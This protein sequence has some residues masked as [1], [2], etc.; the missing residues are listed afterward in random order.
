MIELR[1]HHIGER[2]FCYY[3]QEKFEMPSLWGFFYGGDLNK[4]M[5]DECALREGFTIE[6][7]DL[8]FIRQKLLE[9]AGKVEVGR[10]V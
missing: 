3:H 8:N 4:P 9:N 5:C 7:K 10:A 2:V 1:P 6:Q